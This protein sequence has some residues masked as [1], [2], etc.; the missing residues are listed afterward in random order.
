MYQSIFLDDQQSERWTLGQIRPDRILK[1]RTTR[2][3]AHTWSHFAFW[4]PFVSA[5]RQQ[6][7]RVGDVLKAACLC[8]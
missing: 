7:G 4:V 6:P 5:Q 3:F 8:F 2:Q 1:T